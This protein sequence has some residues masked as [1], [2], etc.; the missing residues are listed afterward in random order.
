MQ[1]VVNYL[2][3]FISPEIAAIIALCVYVFTHHIIQYIPVKYTSKIPDWVMVV[4]NM[5]GAKHG[6]DLAAK[7]DMRGNIQN[8]TGENQ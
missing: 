6:S 7:T 2:W 8:N 3:L 1:E 4:L 5:I